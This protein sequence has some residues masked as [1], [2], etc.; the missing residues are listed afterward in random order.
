MCKLITQDAKFT[1]MCIASQDE[2][3]IVNVHNL[4]GEIP[5]APK[6]HIFVNMHKCMYF[7]FNADICLPFVQL[8]LYADFK[9]LQKSLQ[10]LYTS[11]KE[12]IFY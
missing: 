10:L 12:F 5:H 6:Q 8:E 3:L 9:K 4:S 1:A 11:W 2:G 7:V